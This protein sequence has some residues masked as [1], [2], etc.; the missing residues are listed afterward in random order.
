MLAG[1]CFLLKTQEGELKHT[2]ALVLVAFLVTKSKH[3][4]ENLE[5][6]CSFWTVLS[7]TISPSWWGMCGSG[8]GL[9]PW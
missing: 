6:K 9:C 7:E 5:E 4:M 2:L 8:T 3:L 1:V